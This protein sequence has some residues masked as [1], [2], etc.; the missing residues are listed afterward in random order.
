MADI[1]TTA[2]R[3]MDGTIFST[4]EECN[5][6]EAQLIRSKAPMF[7]IDNQTLQIAS[8]VFETDFVLL[9]DNAVKNIFIN[10]RTQGSSDNFEKN[11]LQ[12]VEGLRNSTGDNNNPDLGLFVLTL[13]YDDNNSPYWKWI[14]LENH[15]QNLSTSIDLGKQAGEMARLQYTS[16]GS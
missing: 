11:K 13:T 8:N 7:K 9:L 5:K 4:E 1:I 2:Y 16:Y 14:S 10:L 3:A 15:L 6:Y 12:S